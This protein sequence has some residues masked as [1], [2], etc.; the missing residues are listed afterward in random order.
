MVELLAVVTFLYVVAG[1]GLVGFS[2]RYRFT[3]K[4]M[5]KSTEM[6]EATNDRWRFWFFIGWTLSLPLVL[7]VEWHVL[8]GGLY[9]HWKLSKPFPEFTYGRKVISDLWTAVAAVLGLLAWNTKP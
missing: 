2:A 4:G 9:E 1:L 8:Y 5:F 7:L 6:D 3:S